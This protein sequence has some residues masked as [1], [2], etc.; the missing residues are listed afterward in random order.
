MTD[1]PD[2]NAS[3]E[4]WLSWTTGR[5]RLASD[6]ARTVWVSANAGSGKTHVLTQRVVRLLLAGARPSAILCLTYTK[7]AASEMSNRVFARLAEWAVLPEEDLAAEIAE[8]EGARP[9]GLKIAVARRL[10]AHALETPGGLKIQTIHAFCESLLHRFPLEANVAGHFSVLDDIAAAT[11]LADARRQLL[12]ATASREDPALSVAFQT[13]LDIADD[14]GLE[15]LLG[16]IVGARHAIRPFLEEARRKDGLAARLRVVYG[17]DADTDEESIA[18]EAWPLSGLEN[19]A[20]LVI[21]ARDDG[22]SRAAGFAD[23]LQKAVE[24][25]DAASR[26]AALES[27]FL[28]S[29][30]TPKAESTL[31]FK[32]LRVKAPELGEAVLAAAQQ[33]F[34][35]RDRLNR[36]RIFEK[37]LAALI[38]ADRLD[39]R[40]EAL[41]Q[42]RGK[43]DFEDLIARTA[44][45]LSRSDA[46]PWVHYKLDQGIDHILVDEAQDTAPLQWDVVRALSE[47]FFTGEGARS[48]L[49]TMFAVGDEKQSIYSF[50]G[51]RPERFAAEGRLTE[52]RVASIAADFSRIGLPLSFRST[53]SVL[54]AVDCVFSIPENRK[55]LSAEGEDTVH[56]SNRLGHPGNV[57]AWEMIAPSEAEDEEDWTAPFDATPEQAPAAILARRIAH[58]ISQTVGRETIVEK[59]RER[60]V[61][62]GDIL[63]L[64][65]KRDAFVNA[66][67]RALKS[68]YDIPVAGADRLKLADH[69]AVK[70]LMALGRF[71]VIPEDDLSL[72]AIF[73]SP[74]LNLSEDDLFAVAARRRPDE[75]VWSALRRLAAA[76]DETFAEAVATLERI[77]NA[78]RRRTAFDFYADILAREGGR[79]AF[80]ARLGS[81]AGD[82]LDEFL[83]AAKDHEDTGLPGL[84]SFLDVMETGGL[85]IKREQDK[86][87]D[88]VRIMTVHASKGLEAPIVFL[89]DSGGRPFIASHL[90][91]FRMMEAG[92]PVWHSSKKEADSGV[93]ADIARREDEAKEEYRRL[94]YVAMT[95]AADRLFITGYRGKTEVPD[96]WHRIVWSALS[97]DEQGRSETIEVSGPFAESWPG[98]LWKENIP[99][100]AFASKAGSAEQEEALPPLPQA[101]FEPFREAARPAPPLSPSQAGLEVEDPPPVTASPL[102]GK[103]AA[104]IALERGRLVHRLMQLLPGFDVSDREDACRRYLSRAALQLPEEAGDAI[105]KNVMSV[106]SDPELAPVFSSAARAEVSVTGTVRLKAADFTVSGRLDRLAVLEEAVLLV[107]FKTNRNPPGADDPVPFSHAAQMA[108]YREILSPLYPEKTVECLLVYTETSS[109]RRLTSRELEEALAALSTK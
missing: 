65:R 98:L 5:Q 105:L 102:F 42:R 97:A 77:I 20:A 95:R 3:P 64:V 73:K 13:V 66:L 30:G 2:A 93:L 76:G 72:A 91:G 8:I 22:G 75:H 36:F 79:R 51:A 83:N 82:I 108:V 21:I 54:S 37:T 52:K 4:D 71:A 59:D 43:L 53:A 101:L 62:A 109:V 40:Y 46:G 31:V 11:L 84:Q 47:D 39:T 88:E 68:P 34:A 23:D 85:E 19:L 96:C 14:S 55:G 104:N 106:M 33:V 24:A 15:K 67:T 16:E 89:V 107:D 70:D 94:L 74:L 100:R 35:L 9:D 90:S 32:S 44:A 78:A 99:P 6:P 50:Q 60:P 27:A 63:V 28:T 48:G 38:L 25:G 1:D 86:G 81:E 10:F 87:R 92:L 26:F 69:I 57:E 80:L 17:F 56:V 49:R 41:K 7:A 103:P 29:A 61:R 12:T 18:G 58:R 45:L